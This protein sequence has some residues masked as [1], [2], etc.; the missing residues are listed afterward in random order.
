MIRQKNKFSV[1]DR[2]E[3]LKPDG[4]DIS[5]RVLR[6]LGKDG[7]QES[8]PHPGQELRILTDAAENEIEAGDIVR[9]EEERNA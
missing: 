9:M 1:G 8:A 4:R 5:C 2:I 7:P 6:I 3:V